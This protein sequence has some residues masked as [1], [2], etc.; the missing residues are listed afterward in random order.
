MSR[1]LL[2]SLAL[3]SL[4]LGCSSDPDYDGDGL[5]L[6]QEEALGTDPNLA[7]TDGDGLTDKEEV[8]A[9]T[10]P[11]EIDTDGDG[12]FDGEEGDHGADPLLVDSDADGYT[13]RDEV[14]EGHDP[15]DPEDRIYIG[16]WPYVYDKSVIPKTA[17]SY[18]EVGNTFFRLKLVDQNG[19]EVDLYDFYNAD[20]PVIIDV[21]AEWCPPCRG[22]A[23]WI[24][25]G[26][27]AY[28]FGQMWPRGP[29]AVKKQEVYWLTVLGENSDGTPAEPQVSVR[30]TDEFPSKRIPVLADGT[31]TAADY[32]GLAWWPYVLLLEP[33]LTL[34]AAN[35]PG[36]DFGSA[37]VVLEEL[38]RR[39]PEN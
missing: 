12:L 9:E 4:A 17:G 16:N 38:D 28:G 32:V 29:Q 5:L 30:W 15:A 36:V 14:F 34:S 13:D 27:D 20:K 23:A 26:D 24:E 6:S 8:D 35:D 25:G 3:A 39:F 11:L 21:S 10:N 33:D 31:Y 37:N 19:Q 22:M 18:R 2:V 1:H 7:D